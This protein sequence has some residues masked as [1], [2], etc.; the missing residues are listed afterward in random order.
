MEAYRKPG[1]NTLPQINFQP[2]FP[3]QKKPKTN[4]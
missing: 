4:K 2:D 3:Q 1:E